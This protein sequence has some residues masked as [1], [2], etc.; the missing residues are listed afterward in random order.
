[1]GLWAAL[2]L[3]LFGSLHCVGMCG[4]LA[5]AL[6]RAG[7]ARGH[8]HAGRVL[9]NLGRVTT[10]ALLGAAFGLAGSA[11]RLAGVQQALSIGTGVVIL[12]WLVL[13]KQLTRRV[14]AS[15]AAAGGIANLKSWF[16][17]LM[18]SHRFAAQFGMGALNGLLPCG[19]VYVGLAGALAQSSVTASAA[20]MALFGLGTL[21]AMLAV[22][23]APGFFSPD[24]RASIRRLLPLG[25]GLVAVLLI[26]RGLSLGIP[27]LSP[28]LPST[29]LAQSSAPACHRH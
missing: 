18:R 1:M 29:P 17:P 22:S 8:F 7:N 6:P 12:L 9:Y 14:A 5:L 21:P 3:G 11:A 26:V 19:F 15:R 10:Y 27:Y 24:S 23:L 2:A 16:S 13:P 20:F 28:E 25:T 4:P